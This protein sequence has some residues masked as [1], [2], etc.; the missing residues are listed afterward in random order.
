M[1]S[2]L[3][4]EEQEHPRRGAGGI[5]TTL[6]RTLLHQQVLIVHLQ[7]LGLV[8]AQGL[9]PWTKQS[10]V[11]LRSLPSL[12]RKLASKSRM[13]LVL[14]ESREE[15]HSTAIVQRKLGGGGGGEGQ[16][17]SRRG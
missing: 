11:P 16:G 2:V 14:E 5:G 7:W 12:W 3:K 1:S 17:G 4:Q 6:R 10:S 13:R 15:S 9:Q 8:S